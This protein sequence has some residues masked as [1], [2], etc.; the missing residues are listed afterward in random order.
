ML[1]ERQIFPSP[2]YPYVQLYDPLVLLHTVSAL[3]FVFPIAH[4]SISE[5]TLL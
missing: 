3:Q 1:P 4:S 2:Q 5:K